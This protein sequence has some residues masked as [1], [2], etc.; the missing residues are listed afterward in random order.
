MNQAEITANHLKEAKGILESM[1]VKFWLT[2]GTALGA[3]RDN[4]FCPGDIDDIDLCVDHE[5]YP[6]AGKISDEF[7]KNG[8][9]I[10]AIWEAKDKISTEYSFYKKYDGFIAKVDLWYYTPNPYNK[11]EVLFRMYREQEISNTYILPKRFHDSF[12]EIEFYGEKY[13]MPEDIEGYL[14]YNYGKDWKTP[15]HR[16]NWDYY[17]SNHSKI[18]QK[19]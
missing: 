10:K 6:M 15:I 17:S 13:L 19:E 5:F 4:D 7:V 14:E 3:Y 11:D 1:G 16:K 9:S 8:W 18:W 12:K 2:L